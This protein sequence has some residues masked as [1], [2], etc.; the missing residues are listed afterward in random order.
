MFQ[1]LGGLGL[2]TGGRASGFWVV[3]ISGSSLW[4]TSRIA[5]LNSVFETLRHR[6]SDTFGW[7]LCLIR[8]RAQ[9][10]ML[11]SSL[12]VLRG[13]IIDFTLLLLDLL[14]EREVV[15][16]TRVYGVEK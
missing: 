11:A 4:A 13:E 15:G 8:K 7:G 1:R 2:R 10:L 3:G 5:G 12:L 14:L 6:Q 9:Q 16:C